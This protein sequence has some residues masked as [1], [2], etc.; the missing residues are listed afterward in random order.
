MESYSRELCDLVVVDSL[1]QDYRSLMDDLAGWRERCH[2]FSTGSEAMRGTNASTSSLWL[3]NSQLPDI[4]GI[5]L[6]SLVRQRVPR[7]RV[8]LVGDHYCPQE[9]S[10]ARA[11]G[12]TAYLCK[13]PTSAWLDNWVHAVRAGPSHS[14]LRS[15]TKRV[16][17]NS[18]RRLSNA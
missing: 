13:P 16:S 15:D 10:A 5:D 7:T 11:A 14:P 2:L 9:E 12:A 8:F 18:P 3:I 17:G 4:S 6:L 1:L